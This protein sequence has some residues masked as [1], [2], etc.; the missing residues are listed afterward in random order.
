MRTWF[1]SV[2]LAVLIVLTVTTV[3]PASALQQMEPSEFV[4][5]VEYALL[6]SRDDKVCIHMLNLFNDDLKQ[7]GYEKY[8]EHEEFRSIGWKKETISRMEGDREVTDFVE[9]AY[10]DINNDG[11]G[12]VVFRLRDFAGG[13]ERD[14]LY[15]FINLARSDKRC[16]SSPSSETVHQEN[17]LAQ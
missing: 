2:L 16:V 1:V 13:Y 3:V 11:S 4:Q 14:T 6:M 9:A 8:D 10:I 7:Y 17:V 12:D 15:I 5:G